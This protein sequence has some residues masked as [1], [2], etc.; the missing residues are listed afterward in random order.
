M[1]FFSS[2]I[3]ETRFLDALSTIASA[4]AGTKT[5]QIELEERRVAA[6]EKIAQLTEMNCCSSDNPKGLHTDA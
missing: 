3:Y 1:P 4:Y 5:K 2:R 6:L